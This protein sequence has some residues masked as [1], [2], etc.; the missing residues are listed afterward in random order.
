MCCLNLANIFHMLIRVLHTQAYLTC[1]FIRFYFYNFNFDPLHLIVL[2][3]THTH[4]QNKLLG[5]SH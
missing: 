5:Y 2:Y 3:I 4:T 1:L